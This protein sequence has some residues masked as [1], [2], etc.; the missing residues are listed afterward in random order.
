MNK[1]QR[2]VFLDALVARAFD[3]ETGD[4]AI[5]HEPKLKGPFEPLDPEEYDIALYPRTEEAHAWLLTQ[6]DALA[7]KDNVAPKGGFGGKYYLHTDATRDLKGDLST[8]GNEE[9]RRY[10]QADEALLPLRPLALPTMPV[11]TRMAVSPVKRTKDGHEHALLVATPLASREQ[12]VTRLRDYGLL[13]KRDGEK[14]GFTTFTSDETDAALCAVPLHTEVAQAFLANPHRDFED[15]VDGDKGPVAPGTLS[16]QALMLEAAEHLR[17]VPLE[18]KEEVIKIGK[19]ESAPAQKKELPSLAEQQ[20]L[21]AALEP[22]VAYEMQPNGELLPWLE[23][24]GTGGLVMLRDAS[25]TRDPLKLG[26]SSRTRTGDRERYQLGREELARIQE[27]LGAPIAEATPEP[28]NDRALQKFFGGKRDHAADKHV[29]ISHVAFA[30]LAPAGEQTGPLYYIYVAASES[31]RLSH[32]RA[33]LNLPPDASATLTQEEEK[34]RLLRLKVPKQTWDTLKTLADRERTSRDMTRYRPLERVDT[35]P[36]YS[37]QALDVQIRDTFGIH[38]A[39]QQEEGKAGKETAGPKLTNGEALQFFVDRIAPID[40]EKMVVATVLRKTTKHSEPHEELALFVRGRVGDLNALTNRLDRET[41]MFAKGSEV[42]LI[43]GAKGVSNA[44]GILEIVVSPSILTALRAQGTQVERLESP[45]TQDNY[46]QA[47]QALFMTREKEEVQRSAEEE[48]WQ[49]LGKV[50]VVPVKVSAPNKERLAMLEQQVERL[51]ALS[52]LI[53]A[54]LRELEDAEAGYGDILK[55]LGDNKGDAVVM[56]ELQDARRGIRRTVEQVENGLP[57]RITRRVEALQ[58]QYTKIKAA[59]LRTEYIALAPEQRSQKLLKPLVGPVLAGD[60]EEIPGTRGMLRLVPHH[61]G[62]FADNLRRHGIFVH[63]ADK[64]QAVPDDD[65][66]EWAVKKKHARDEDAARAKAARERPDTRVHGS[67]REGV[68]GEKAPQAETPAPYIPT[69]NVDKQVE[70]ALN[71]TC[72][73]LTW[74]RQEPQ[75]ENT[76]TQERIGEQAVLALSVATHEELKAVK[77]LYHVLKDE[78]WLM[79]QPRFYG[80]I[81]PGNKSEPQAE[82]RPRTHND[83]AARREQLEAS[84]AMFGRIKASLDDVRYFA[85]SAQPQRMADA[86]EQ[87]TWDMKALAAEPVNLHEEESLH[88]LLTDL[89]TGK[90]PI[91]EVDPVADRKLRAELG[92]IQNELLALAPDMPRPGHLPTFKPKAKE[93]YITSVKVGGEFLYPVDGRAGSGKEPEQLDV[94]R[95]IV[96]RKHQDSERP[97]GVAALKLYLR[98]EALPHLQELTGKT[99]TVEDILAGTHKDAYTAEMIATRLFHLQQPQQEKPREGRGR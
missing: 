57:A 4:I 11:R 48:A 54:P 63:N 76:P 25:R 20:E 19:T 98:P 44:N 21:L 14:P 96:T 42:N 51:Q 15:W 56:R 36:S 64:A 94:W 91:E 1:Q 71:G 55:T 79:E 32:V 77:Q 23:V 73:I 37:L 6:K 45:L 89:V 95:R 72:G 12:A 59:G 26:N 66:P 27:A 97:E 8:G 13:P 33:S 61:P 18:K 5:H 10:P 49:H 53:N 31:T 9:R 2:A 83:S 99:G 47:I 68:A 16:L 3:G 81:K 34:P 84:E 38:A 62:K 41:D 24:N 78:G 17:P 87:L 80:E 75:F 82:E 93:G 7:T 67:V 74:E 52:R 43:S 22:K 35:D 29:P 88:A 58:L 50:Q 60:I 86:M 39:K 69:R 28:F 65:L 70:K 85:K 46:H 92:R 30:E 90:R 40:P